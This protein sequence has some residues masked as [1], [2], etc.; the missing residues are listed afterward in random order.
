METMVYLFILSILTVA[1]IS[2]LMVM[3]R[4]SAASRIERNLNQ[5]AV[6]ALGRVVQE[7]RRA[8]SA[9]VISAN[10]LSL[11]TTDWSGVAT[12]VQLSVQGGVL[13]IQSGA[14]AA[15]PLTLGHSQV[16]SLTFTKVTTKHSQAVRVQLSLT[17]SRGSAPTTLNFNTT[18]VLRGSY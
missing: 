18:T 17:D 14:S 1:L 4:S 5:S 8:N 3:I 10:Q 7:L 16:S 15:V 6:S 11:N 2:A 13:M 12:T 9:T